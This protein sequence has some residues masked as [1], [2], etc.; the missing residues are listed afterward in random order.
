[1]TTSSLEPVLAQRLG[2]ERLRQAVQERYSAVAT[3]P[4][5]DYGFRVGREFALALGYPPDLLDRL[6]ASSVASFTGVATPVFSAALR[7]GERVLDLGCGAGVDTA[8]AAEAVGSTGRVIALDF[9]RAMVRQT[10]ALVAGRHYERVAVCQ[11]GAE[12]LPLPD[13][14]VDCVLVNGLFNLAPEKG[15]VLA[16]VARVTCPGGRLVA[17][18]T[19]LTRPLA[20]DELASLDDWF[21]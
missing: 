8:V 18:E 17:A 16:E 20:E 21:R 6:P 4:A 9:A 10:S 15:R 12:A 13:A 5:G 3:D 1:M 2:P 19:V 14:S 7:P 11:A